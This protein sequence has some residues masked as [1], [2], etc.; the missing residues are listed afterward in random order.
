MVA[1][2]RDS[3]RGFSFNPFKDTVTYLFSRHHYLEPDDELVL[4]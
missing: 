2:I 3:Q 4:Y 1:Q